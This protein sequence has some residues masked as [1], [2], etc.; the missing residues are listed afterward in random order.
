MGLLLQDGIELGGRGDGAV[1][2]SH[3]AAEGLSEQLVDQELFVGRADQEQF[4]YEAT[5]HQEQLDRTPH[6]P[7]ASEYLAQVGL[8][9]APIGP[10]VDVERDATC[11]DQ[12]VSGADPLAPR[13]R[14]HRSLVILVP[15]Y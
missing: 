13:S 5:E 6:L 3:L 9:A 11:A 10:C 15:G 1:Q 4:L 8:G 14:R 7:T 2:L 12:R